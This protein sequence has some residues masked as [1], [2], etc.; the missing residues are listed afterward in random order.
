[1][2]TSLTPTTELEAVN[3]MLA[4]IGEAAVSSLDE[5]TFEDAQSAVTAL[6]MTSREVQTKGCHFNTEI[7]LEL[8]PDGD[9]YLQ[10]PA[11]AMRVDSVA[12]DL[13]KDVVQ[14]GQRL[15]DRRNHTY[16]FERPMKVDI[17]VLLAFEELPEYARQYIY[18]KA[19]RQFINDMQGD[20]T[21]HSIKER[22]ELRALA[23]FSDAEAQATDANIFRGD[24]N[25]FRT[26]H[27]RGW[28]W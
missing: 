28:A 20:S 23:D 15:Y 3:R 25:T 14:R 11:N 9:G 22:D 26:V 13:D 4:A 6:R 10:L 17:T 7:E 27:R 2:S 18:I 5:V 21:S 24:W 12:D 16:V 19:A 1:M 8:T